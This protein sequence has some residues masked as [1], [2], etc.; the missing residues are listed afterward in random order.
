MLSPAQILT[1]RYQ[2]ERFCKKVIADERRDFDKEVLRRAKYEC[3]FSDLPPV[4][5]ESFCTMEPYPGECYIF[6]ANGYPVPI[7]SDRLIDVLLSFTADEYSILL[8]AYALKFTD[9]DIAAE[10]ST[11]RSNIQR[12]RKMLFEILQRK[13]KE[14]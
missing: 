8:L 9:K 1:N 11:S 4:M 7:R 2:F 13:M 6:K 10:L 14:D 3:N 5:T 12:K